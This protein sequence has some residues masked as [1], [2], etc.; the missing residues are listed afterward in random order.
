M[1][2]FVYQCIYYFCA[3]RLFGLAE[4][5]YRN[6]FLLLPK[7]EKGFVKFDDLIDYLTSMFDLSDVAAFKILYNM[8]WR[9]KKIISLRQFIN[10]MR[11][12]QGIEQPVSKTSKKIFDFYD[13]DNNGYT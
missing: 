12:L 3:D 2:R 9:K 1:S 6:E 5:D 11:K 8:N 13:L 4:E 10:L 7:D